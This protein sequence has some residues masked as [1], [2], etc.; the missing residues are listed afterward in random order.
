M[1][2]DTIHEEQ[3]IELEENVAYGPSTMN[4]KFS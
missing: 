2:P 3:A 1:I 4:I